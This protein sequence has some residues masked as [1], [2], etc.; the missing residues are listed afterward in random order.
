MKE[1]EKDELTPLEIAECKTGRR[2][3]QICRVKGA[4]NRLRVK[5]EG[6]AA[7]Y[8]VMSR[9][10]GGEFLLDD[11]AKEA[12]RR[13]MWRMSRFAGVEVLTYCVMDN[14]FHVLV[15]VPERAKW[16]R[17]FDGEGGEEKF[18]K[19]LSCVYSKAFMTQLRVELADY[20]ASG[21]D[22]LADQLLQSFKDRLCDVSKFVK[23]LKERFTRWYNKIHGR[24]GTLWMDRFKSVLV[25]DG[26]AL[27]TMAAYIDLNPVRAGLVA[28]DRPED[29][30][31]CGYAEA[32]AG[33][34]RMRRGLCRVMEVPQDSWL[35]AR[36]KT[37][38]SRAEQ[39]KAKKVT[40]AAMYCVLLVLEEGCVSPKEMSEEDLEKAKLS[41]PQLL[42]CRVRYFTEGIALGGKQ[43]VDGLLRRR[44]EEGELSH[45]R[46]VPD[47][48][49]TGAFALH[50][51]RTLHER[52]IQVPAAAE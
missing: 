31:F 47:E 4:G 13:M 38:A 39:R 2:M 30:R 1:K 33:S 22:V 25:Q 24:R 42:R 27:R 35:L 29:Y 48:P 51:L 10:V 32:V 14:H 12:F 6:E 44:Y 26:K 36:E 43:F 7:C 52:G 37:A 8:H 46:E 19:H 28:D 20:R 23:E 18:L 16:L 34:K 50:S 15:R 17:R 5:V 9:T 45:D 49:Q 40:P 41:V 21:R 11:E 3:G